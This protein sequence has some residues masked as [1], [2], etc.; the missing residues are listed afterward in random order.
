VK[1]GFEELTAAFE[2]PSQNARVWTEQWVGTWL[3]CPSCGAQNMRAFPRNN[4]AGDFWCEACREEYELKAQKHRFGRKVTD[5]AYGTMCSRL[6][7][8][9]NP[10]LILMNYDPAPERR[11]VTDLF[12]VP[13]QFFVRDI[14]EERPPLKATARRAGWVGC[15]ILLERVPETGKVF[16]IKDRQ[17]QPKDQVLAQWE[18]TRFL[19]E[20]RPEARGWLI[21]V[22]NCVDAIG[23]P[24]FTLEDV[25][26]YEARLHAI[27]PGNNNVRPKIRQQLQ[28]LRDHGYL[29]FEGGGRY[30]LAGS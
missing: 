25:Y 26:A 6:A 17:V 5:G 13:K 27:Y 1:L 16:V 22:M 12:V 28:V 20:A 11:G 24:E 18:S 3:F 14:I 19:R 30:A 9:N 8:D 21:E 7:A 15:N 10:N 2:S 29:R 4:P 23:R